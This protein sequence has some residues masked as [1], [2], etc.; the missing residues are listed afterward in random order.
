MFKSDKGVSLITLVITIVAMLVILSIVINSSIDSVEETNI[1]KIQ[2]ETKDLRDAV[3]DR[4]ANNKRNSVLYPIIGEKI[5]DSIFEYIRSIEYLDSQEINKIIEQISVTYS[6]EY[7][8]YYRL[9]GRG[10][11]EK[12]GVENIDAEHFYIVDY[13]ECEVYGPISLEVM[14]GDGG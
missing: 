3:N 14:S 4:I 10:E 12:L 6:A 11:A 9:V 8:D 13:Y 2:N 1:T 7:S 5:G